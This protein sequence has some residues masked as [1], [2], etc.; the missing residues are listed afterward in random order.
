MSDA[1]KQLEELNAC[2]N[3]CTKCPLSA[4]R[5]NGVPG[6]GPVPCDVLF[7]GEGPGK[8]E[9]LQGRPF[10]GRAGD[11]LVELLASIGKTREEVFIAN[12]VKC[13][14][15][16]NRDPKPEEVA[17]CWPYLEEQVKLIDPKLVVLLGRHAM[18]RFLPG[19]KISQD[20]GEPK[21]RKIEGLGTRVYMPIYHPAAALYNPQ[22]KQSLLDDFAKIPPIIEKIK[23]LMAR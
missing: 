3:E 23:Q 18:D 19:Q 4:T 13:R 5:T 1:T 15:P 11:L 9:D 2:V 14:P 17:E 8:N 7:I 10:V 16:G 22:L 21:R 20:R 6:E 12:V